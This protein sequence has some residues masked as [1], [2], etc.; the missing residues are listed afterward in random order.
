MNKQKKWITAALALVACLMV[1]GCGGNMVSQEKY[2]EVVAERDEL[3]RNY[4]EL[5][6]EYSTA[7]AEE[8]VANLKNKVQEEIQEDVQQGAVA[9][10][11]SPTEAAANTLVYEDERVRIYYKGLNEKGVVFSVDNMTDVIITIQAEAIS[12]NRGSINDIMMSDPVSPQSTGDVVA[13][14]DVDPNIDVTEVGG[15]LRVV[16][17]SDSFEHYNATFVNVPIG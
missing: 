15:Q 14:C 5:L 9:S 8:Q 2:A 17:F 12:L 7:Y 13:R 1:A 16:D 10:E 6:E 3:Q 11:P 4:D